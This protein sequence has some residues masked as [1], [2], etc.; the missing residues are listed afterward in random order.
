LAKTLWEIY[1]EKKL[2]KDANGKLVMEGAAATNLDTMLEAA[3]DQ[4]STLT[5]LLTGG[6]FALISIGDIKDMKAVID[7]LSIEWKALATFILALPMILWV[8][9]LAY[10]N[11]LYLSAIKADDGANYEDAMK[12]KIEISIW[13]MFLGLIVLILILIIYVA[14]PTP[15]K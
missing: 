15:S 1:K 3:K 12:D 5:T 2:S 11:A 8:A 13:L 10:A 14:V 6:Y 4:I 7:A 9:S